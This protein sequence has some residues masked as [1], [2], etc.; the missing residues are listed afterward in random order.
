[1]NYLAGVKAVEK[2]MR[3]FDEHANEF[4]NVAGRHPHWLLTGIHPELRHGI[5]EHVGLPGLGRDATPRAD[6]GGEGRRSLWNRV[7]QIK[8]RP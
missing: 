1:M 7:V 5:D 3:V 2:V 8:V 4:D 6:A